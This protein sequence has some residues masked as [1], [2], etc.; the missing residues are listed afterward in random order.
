MAVIFTDHRCFWDHVDQEFKTCSRRDWY[1]WQNW[2]RQ[3]KPI[4]RSDIKSGI[5]S[6]IYFILMPSILHFQSRTSIVCM[7]LE[8]VDHIWQD[9]QEKVERGLLKVNPKAALGPS[10]RFLLENHM[11]V[12][13]VM[14]E[15]GQSPPLAPPATLLAWEVRRKLK[16]EEWRRQNLSQL[17][18]VPSRWRILRWN[19]CM[20]SSRLRMHVLCIFI[21]CFIGWFW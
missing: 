11:V 16:L 6:I 14:R 13:T 10:Q 17:P 7:V 1:M 20:A 3:W 12:Q 4:V 8:Q 15:L 2:A 19:W 9:H 21:S 18:L 5:I